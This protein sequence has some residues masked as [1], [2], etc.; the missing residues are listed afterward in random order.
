MAIQQD[1]TH[2]TGVSSDGTGQDGKALTH[3]RDRKAEA[4]LALK[5]DNVSWQDIADELGYPTARHAL[6]AVE[7]ALQ[8]S[9]DTLESK[10]FMRRLASQ[11]LEDLVYAMMQKATDDQDAEQIAAAREARQLLMDHAK[12]NGYVMPTEVAIYNPLDAEIEKLVGD[13]TRQAMPSIEAGNIFEMEEGE[14]GVFVA[15]QPEPGDDF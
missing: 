1:S 15:K 8:K 7:K 3:A 13:L 4:A 12:L 14:D 9:L 6:V 11:K 2:P 10:D 5:R